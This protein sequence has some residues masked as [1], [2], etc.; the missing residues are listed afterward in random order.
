MQEKSISN[1]M[2]AMVP[3]T[4][5]N[6][7]EA[8]KIFNEVEADGTKIVVKNNR[9][10]CVLVSP[11][12]YEALMETLSEYMLLAETEKR[13]S[14]NNDRE[15]ISHEEVKKKLGITDEDLASIDVEIE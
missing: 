3:I 11:D 9:P 7:G 8:S 14:N 6:K 2:N 13:I 12:Q 4:R 5:F 10:A 1:I 15:N